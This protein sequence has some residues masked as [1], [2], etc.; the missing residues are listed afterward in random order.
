MG[1]GRVQGSSGM[2]LKTLI[3]A[4][5][6]RIPEVPLSG[7]PT[8]REIRLQ[9]ILTD[10]IGFLRF[11]QAGLPEWTEGTPTESGFYLVEIIKTNPDKKQVWLAWWNGKAWYQGKIS[12]A[13]SKTAD[14]TRLPRDLTVLRY[15]PLPESGCNLKGSSWA[16]QIKGATDA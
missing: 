16:A 14:M 3:E 11:I 1:L 4:K 12:P 8:D 15:L 13:D 6:E 5:L 7:P 2:N 9:G 10:L